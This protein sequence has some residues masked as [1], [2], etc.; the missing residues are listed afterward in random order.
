MA[1]RPATSPRVQG[2][3]AVL[4]VQGAGR[5]ADAPASPAAV[6]VEVLKFIPPEL[7]APAQPWE[8]FLGA[9]SLETPLATSTLVWVHGSEKTK[10]ADAALRHQRARLAPKEKGR[11]G[12]HLRAVPHLVL[13]SARALPHPLAEWPG[14]RLASPVLSLVPSLGAS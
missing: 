3:G 8:V 11:E 6:E 1:S 9:G 2:R 12:L 14:W 7:R 13:G 4:L 5:R 10:K